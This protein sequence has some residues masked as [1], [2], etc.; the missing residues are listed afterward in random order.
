MNWSPL[1]RHLRNL[2]QYFKNKLI[3][4]V[5]KD[6]VWGFF[7]LSLSLFFFFLVD[8]IFISFN[9]DM[10]C[11]EKLSTLSNYYCYYHYFFHGNVGVAVV[12][13]SVNFVYNEYCLREISLVKFH[14][15][16]FSLNL[17]L[18][19]THIAKSSINI[20]HTKKYINSYHVCLQIIIQIRTP[21]LSSCI[22]SLKYQS[23]HSPQSPFFISIPV[24]IHTVSSFI[25]R[26]CGWNLYIWSTLALCFPFAGGDG[27]RDTCLLFPKWSAELWCKLKRERERERES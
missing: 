24:V 4:D 13:F 8:F 27:Q 26:M 3:I 25:F 11:V 2:S 15:T 16:K 10:R 1:M 14:L 9:V 22:V 23:L 5:S 19:Y 20:I 17:L 7:F 18:S 12:F 21:L 6:I